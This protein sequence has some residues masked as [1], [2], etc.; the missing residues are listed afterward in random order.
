MRLRICY[1][2][3]EHR[4]CDLEVTDSKKKVWMCSECAIC[5]PY[6]INGLH[7]DMENLSETEYK[8]TYKKLLGEAVLTEREED[9]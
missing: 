9:D 5:V 4:E 1:E 3:G 8:D 6:I 7:P 2:C